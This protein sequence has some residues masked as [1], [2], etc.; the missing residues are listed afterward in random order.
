[1]ISLSFSRRLRM[2]I[3]VGPST[4]I[5]KDLKVFVVDGGIDL[6]VDPSTINFNSLEVEFD[7]Y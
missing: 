3:G 2:R 5:K 7:S 6:N 4:E 1:M